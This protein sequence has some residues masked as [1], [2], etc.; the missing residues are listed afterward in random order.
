MPIGR[1]SAALVALGS[2]GV[3]A[4]GATEAAAPD[5]TLPAP[6]AT[7]GGVGAVPDTVAG[8]Q[9]PIT[10]IPRPVD[11]EGNE[12][13]L[14]G[15]QVDGNR[16]L[17]IGDSIFAGT[18]TRYGGQ[19]CD[20]LVPLGWTVA[21]EAEPSRSVEFG[22]QVLDEMLDPFSPDGEWDVAAV[23]LGTN[24]RGDPVQYEAELREIL[25]RLSPRPTILVSVALYRSNYFEV[26]EVINRLA[27]EFSFVTVVDWTSLSEE[28]GMLSG[29]GL[30]PSNRGR[31]ALVESIAA[32]LGPRLGVGECLG[33]EF[34]DDSAIAAGGSIGGGGS[35]SSSSG[36]GGSFSGSASGTGSSGSG[37]PSAGDVGA[38][39]PPAGTVGGGSDVGDPGDAGDTGTGD[40]GESDTAGDTGGLGS[41]GST[42]G[43]TGTGDT[44]SGG[45]TGGDTG[46]GST[47]GDTGGD[48]GGGADGGATGGGST[49]G[50][51]G[52]DSGGGADGGADGGATGGGS[53]GGD[54]GGDPGGGTGGGSTGGDTGGDPGGGSAGGET[55]GTTP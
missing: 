40:T 26:N 34:R 21:V 9:R 6:S 11:E 10:V 16:F 50:D 23:F 12:I 47:G 3:A 45:D 17:A 14:I 28:P 1:T 30:H 27:D 20:V 29:D 19:M 48:T 51:T 37:S 49:G 35:S 44:G 33:A 24:Y 2:L 18:S 13:L 25:T 36:S 53:T 4:C 38:T 41:D 32:E 52:G 22:N 5:S 55:G 46:G 42:G 31:Q 54:T 39:T 15:E 7:I 8:D 43:D